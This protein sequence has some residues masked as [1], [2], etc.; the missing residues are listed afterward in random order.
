MQIIHFVEN[1][2]RGGLERTVIELII[3]Q[4]EAGHDCRV[5]C[6]FEPGILAAELAAQGVP[7]DACHKR[8]GFDWQA[9]RRARALLRD[10]PPGAVLHTHNASA[11]YHALSAAW[12]LPMGHVVST[13]HSPGSMDSGSRKEWLYRQSMRGTDYVVAVSEAVRQHFAG[14]G[15]RPRVAL[16]SIPNGIR[17]DRFTPANAQA[18]AALVSEMGWPE[19]SRVIGTVG[20]L[21]PVKGQSH[22][23]HALRALRQKVPQ[24]VLAIVGDGG[25]RSALEQETDELGLRPWV[26]FLGDRSDVPQLLQAMEV[27]ALPSLSE[28]YSIALLEACAAALPIVATDVGGNREIVRD[29]N[30]GRLIAAGNA[31]VLADALCDVLASEERAQQMGRAGREWVLEAG[32]FRNMAARYQRLYAGNMVRAD[33]REAA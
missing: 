26:R 27:F 29:G 30:N 18:R 12:G 8:T 22:L 10:C 4:R 17:V 33:L 7:V 21:H 14:Q 2:E 11:H 24:A 9:M 20:R 5:I 15:L 16:L 19:G 31:G 6:L 32:T 1:L 28:G 25:M 3:A 23:L 13:R